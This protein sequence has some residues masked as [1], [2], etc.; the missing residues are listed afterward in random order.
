MGSA[1]KQRAYDRLRGRIPHERVPALRFADP[2][3]ARRA[4]TPPS[5]RFCI[6]QTETKGK[7][8]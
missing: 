5:G 8:A 6:D 4:S 1:L 7:C 3:S 2:C